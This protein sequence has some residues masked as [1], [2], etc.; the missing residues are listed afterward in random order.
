MGVIFLIFK[1]LSYILFPFFGTA[2]GAAA[3]FFMKKEPRR[4]LY[5]CLS[6]G[7]AGVMTAA[8]VWSLIIPAVEASQGL[9][10]FAFLPAFVGILLG[11]TFI[12]ITDTFIPIERLTAKACGDSRSC[13]LMIFAV[14]LHNLPEGI[15][16][17]AAFASAFRGEGSFAGA[18]ALSLGIGLQ[19]IPE[20][21][22]ISLPLCSA[23]QKKSR[24]FYT[25]VLSGVVEPLG[26]ALSLL[27]S[28]VGNILPYLLGFAA[29]TMLYVSAAELIPEAKRGGAPFFILGFLLMMTLDI[30]LG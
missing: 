7:A 16:V 4:A 10:R 28:S 25:G 14:T 12:F 2:A 1:T 11:A 26:A 20:G 17:G 13:A 15:A 27:I 24:A 6:G 23:G 21:A 8:S 9:G 30:A 22:I 29:G 19:N 18:A 3:V 5:N